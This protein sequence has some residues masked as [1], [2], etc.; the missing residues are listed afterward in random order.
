MPWMRQGKDQEMLKIRWVLFA[1][2]HSHSTVVFDSSLF[3]ITWTYWLLVEKKPIIF[4]A[5]C[6]CFHIL[7][8]AKEAMN[9]YGLFNWLEKT[10]RYF[11]LSFYFLSSSKLVVLLSWMLML[12]HHCTK[13][14]LLQPMTNSNL[15]GL[16][17][18]KLS[19]ILT[20]LVVWLLYVFLNPPIFVIPGSWKCGKGY[21]HW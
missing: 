11:Y 2:V 21:L 20:V 17:F 19:V 10:F 16:R 4:W 6:R 5:K 15:F 13:R 1:R 3:N 12:Q 8:N 7:N 14:Q 18:V 9:D